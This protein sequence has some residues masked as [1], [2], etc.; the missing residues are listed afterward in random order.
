MH[1]RAAQRESF[2]L[3]AE[4]CPAVD[5]ALDEAAKQIKVQTGTLR[6][7]LTETLERAI[8]HARAALA[9]HDKRRC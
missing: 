1:H 9:A 5:N 3:V 2:Q 7:A 4:T 8:E 6:D